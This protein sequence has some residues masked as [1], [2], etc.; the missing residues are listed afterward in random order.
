MLIF[1]RTTK[2]GNCSYYFSL[3]PHY[4]QRKS[5]HVPHVLCSS[6]KHISMPFKYW[7]CKDCEIHVTSGNKGGGGGGK[8][9]R[10]QGN[11]HYFLLTPFKPIISKKSNSLSVPFTTKIPTKIFLPSCEW[12]YIIH[13]S[14]RPV[15][16]WWQPV[17]SDGVFYS[18]R[19][20]KK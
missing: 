18:T 1:L 17:L 14:K 3:K 19:K 20:K 12:L 13:F 4:E 5:S 6:P 8:Q 10:K 11:D 7:F 15:V 16:R 9:C 2:G